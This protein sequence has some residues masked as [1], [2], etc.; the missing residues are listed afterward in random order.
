MG[1]T[2]AQWCARLGTTFT[3]PVD[4]HAYRI[5]ARGNF[6]GRAR[7]VHINCKEL[8]SVITGTRW[9]SRARRT[10]RCRLLLQSDSAVVVGA[11]RKGRSSKPGL[12]VQLRRLAALTL[13]ERIALVGRYVPTDRN[14]ADSPSR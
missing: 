12:L 7:E 3:A 4:P 1:Q 6:Q 13:A 5:A 14:M 9:A 10:R 8:N 2:R 11:L